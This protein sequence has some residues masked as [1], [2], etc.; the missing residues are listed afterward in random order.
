MKIG[1]NQHLLVFIVDL[2]IA[3]ADV[4]D[5]KIEDVGMAIGFA[6]RSLGEIRLSLGID[7][8]VSDGMIYQ[9]LP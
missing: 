1:I 9:E 5:C 4:S 7:L 8:K 3:E 2:T 6:R